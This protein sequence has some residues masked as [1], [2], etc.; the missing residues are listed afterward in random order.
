MIG[1]QSPWI[2]SLLLIHGADQVTTLEYAE[3]KSEHPQIHTVTPEQI[4]K[5]YL[6]GAAPK[7][8]AMV[9]FSSLEHSG[10]GRYGDSLNPWGDLITMAKAWCLMK[11]GGRALIG[12]PSGMDAILFNGNRLYGP[13]MYSHLFANWNQIYSEYRDFDNGFDTDPR[14]FCECGRTCENIMWCYQ[15][16]SVIE[17]PMDKGCPLP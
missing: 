2:E 16:M 9:T 3:I 14:K 6:S 4:R 12:V 11:P 5:A 7:F 13:I 15:P 10:L 1:S 17:K 8:D